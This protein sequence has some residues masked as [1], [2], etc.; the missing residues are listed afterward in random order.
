[1]KI[2]FSFVQCLCMIFLFGLLQASPGLA[3]EPSI[4]TGL[5]DS[6]VTV[7][8]ELHIFI[9][10]D[11]DGAESSGGWIDLVYD[12]AVLLRVD[13]QNYNI[14][15]FPGM[16]MDGG[17]LRM[18]SRTA[19]C[20]DVI[21]FPSTQTYAEVTFLA[22]QPVTST[23]VYFAETSQIFGTGGGNILTTLD[24]SATRH[25][26]I[27]AE[28]AQPPASEDLPL[29]E[30]NEPGPDEPPDVPLTIPEPSTWGLLLFGLGGMLLLRKRRN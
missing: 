24:D 29:P 21:I 25:I 11:L 17:T 22:L 16:E 30:P 15:G 1:M 6:T 19:S 7:G 8:D 20:Y 5:A 3:S 23:A 14:F 28:P 13:I 10:L 27:E 18:T 26:T 4:Q 9:L 2:K 12:P